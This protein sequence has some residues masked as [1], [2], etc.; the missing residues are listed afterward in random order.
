[1]LAAWRFYVCL[2]FECYVKWLGS[3]KVFLEFWCTSF[4]VMCFAGSTHGILK[5][6]RLTC[7]D[8]KDNE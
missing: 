6:Q 4:N 8:F 1:M 2:P 7:S 3:F 5:L